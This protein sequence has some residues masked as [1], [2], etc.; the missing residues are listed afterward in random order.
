MK[1]VKELLCFIVPIFAI[2]GCIYFLLPDT[3]FLSRD[4]YIRL[5]FE[6]DL[7][8]KAMIGSLIASFIVSAVAF[9]LKCS[10][11]KKFRIPRTLFYLGTVA[12]VGISVFVWTIV[13]RL[14]AQTTPSVMLRSY[15]EPLVSSKE[16]LVSV[17][18]AVFA[19]FVV[20]IV[21]SVIDI[22][23]K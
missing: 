17:L 7:W 23:K 18:F 6:D 10:F 12:V 11:S 1:K 3:E 9:I 2:L 22:V 15:R 4:G 5:H 13:E 16:I 14:I 21:E 8:I 20:W 19:A